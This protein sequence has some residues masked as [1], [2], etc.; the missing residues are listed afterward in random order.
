MLGIYNTKI[1]ANT[2]WNTE[3]KNW[4]EAHEITGAPV[5]SLP[6]RFLTPASLIPAM[7]AGAPDGSLFALA[8]QTHILTNT[9]MLDSQPTPTHPTYAITAVLPSLQLAQVLFSSGNNG[10]P[11]DL[12]R[13]F[14]RW[15]QAVAITIVDSTGPITYPCIIAEV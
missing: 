7:S 9:L 8:M 11:E 14:F 1:E 4:V 15:L 10:T 5:G 2:G 6:L 13:N 12:Q 3:L